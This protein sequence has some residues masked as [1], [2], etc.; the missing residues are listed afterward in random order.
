MLVAPGARREGADL[1]NH[2]ATTPEDLDY[3]RRAVA[4]GD[5]D[6]SL[7]L[8]YAIEA[9]RARLAALYAFQIELR[10]IPAIVSEPPLGEIR[11]QWWREA[12]DE[13]AAGAPARA[14]PVVS[15]L[16]ASGAVG[17]EMRDVAEGLIDAR[18]RLLYEPRFA[19][20]DDLR[21]FLRG[22]EAPLARLALGASAACPAMAAASLA[23]A[24]AL[25]RFAPQLAPALANEASAAAAHLRAQTA[26]GIIQLSPADAGRLA[27]L[28]LTRGYAARAD[29]RRWPVMKR[30]AMFRAVLTGRF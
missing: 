28:S 17:G 22:A 23:E 14:H 25:A 13:I 30:L 7:S 9:D 16:A 8:N 6:Y 2:A 18:A 11:L 10:R 3:C 20:L 15:L 29:G 24:Y 27:P 5:E 26:S 4:E 12:L 1:E 21:E 19:S